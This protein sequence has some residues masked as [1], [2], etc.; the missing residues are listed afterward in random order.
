[1]MMMMMGDNE[2]CC[3][4]DEMEQ[5]NHDGDVVDVAT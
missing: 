5:K 3:D 2:E 1:M 4:G